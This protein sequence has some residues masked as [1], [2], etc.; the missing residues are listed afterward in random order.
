MKHF[1][2][3]M[4]GV[5]QKAL[6]PLKAQSSCRFYPSCSAYASDALKKHGLF[7][8]L[9]MIG[10]RLVRCHPFHPGGVDLVPCASSKKANRE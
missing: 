5:Y 4:I 7:R 1:L 3:F 2:L 8:A 9:T 6:S 10:H